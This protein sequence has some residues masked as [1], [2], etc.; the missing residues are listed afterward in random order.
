[1][2]IEQQIAIGALVAAFLVPAL[3]LYV[4]NRRDGRNDFQ[5]EAM[6]RIQMLR[7]QLEDCREMLPFL[8]PIAGGEAAVDEPLILPMTPRKRDNT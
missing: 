5:S 7:D 8:P 6:A 1:M 3:T 2:T 4:Q